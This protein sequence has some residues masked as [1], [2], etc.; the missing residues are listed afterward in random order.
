MTSFHAASQALQALVLSALFILIAAI[1]LLIFI[2][3]FCRAKAY[4]LA[5]DIA[6]LL[7]LMT[8]TLLLGCVH[9]APLKGVETVAKMQPFRHCRYPC[10]SC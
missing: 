5:A 10:T 3:G 1:L 9:I 7:I 4:G 2:K 6:V 8:D